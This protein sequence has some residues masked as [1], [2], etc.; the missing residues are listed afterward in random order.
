M[1]LNETYSKAHIGK[2]FSDSFPI[3]NFVRRQCIITTAF[4][5][6]FG[7]YNKK[8]PQKP[9]G[10]KWNGPHQLLAYADDVHL[11]GGNTEAIKINTQTVTDASKEIGLVVTVEKTKHMLLSQYQNAGQ[12]QNIRRADHLEM[13]HDS[14]SLAWE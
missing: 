10:L 8:S 13:C 11:L 12:N 4:E 5:L 9:G 7:I 2:Y 6:C 1:Y 14:K 3:L